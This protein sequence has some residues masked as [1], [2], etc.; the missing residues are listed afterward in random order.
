[1]QDA[2]KAFDTPTLLEIWRSGPYLHDGRAAT[3]RD[4]IVTEGH[5]SAG[6]LS[7]V[8]IDELITYLLS[9]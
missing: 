6:S 7:P 1:G 9:L 2:G 4:V 3:V 5:G 8:E